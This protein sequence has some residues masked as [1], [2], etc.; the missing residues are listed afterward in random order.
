MP[1]DIPRYNVAHKIGRSPALDFSTTFQIDPSHVKD[2]TIV[3]TGGASGFGAGFARKWASYG[4]NIIIGDISVPAGE[5]IVAELRQ[6]TNNKNHHFI[7]LDVTS[8]NSQVIFF[9]QAAQLSPHGGIDTVVVNAGI[10]NSEEQNQFENPTNVDYLND[11]SPP[12]PTMATIDVNLTGALYTTHLGIWY[13]ERNPNSGS[14]SVG[15]R[16]RHLL[17]LGSVA[18]LFPIITQPYYAVSKHGI[19]ALFRC[20]RAGSFVVHGIRVNLICPYFIDTPIVPP[21][22]KLILAG[23]ATGVV[24]DVVQAASLFVSRPDIIGRAVVVG[25]KVKIRVPTDSEGK[26][27]IIGAA[28]VPQIENSFEV[29]DPERKAKIQ[30]G[31]DGV[32][33]ERAIW[34]FYAEDFED[35]DLFTK[36]MVTILNA[37]G[38]AKGWVGFFRDVAGAVGSGVSKLVFGR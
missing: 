12:P 3:I 7:R 20:L 14:L 9:R 8:W 10:N 29:I 33:Q 38:A 27:S 4:A 35:V 11:P 21:A 16:D 31:P 15:G 13:L 19:L 5:A 28:G 22:G 18:S 37:F 32:V 30:E 26:A 36:R 25:P 1:G 23:G 24:E 2:K 34:E 6:K 17:L